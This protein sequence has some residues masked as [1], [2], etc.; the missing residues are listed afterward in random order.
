[1]HAPFFLRSRSGKPPLRIGVLL[2]TAFLPACF[3]EVLDHIAQSNF[4]RLEIAVFNGEAGLRSAPENGGRRRMLFDLYEQWD[5]KRTGGE[6]DPLQPVDCSPRLKGLESITVTPITRGAADEF[7]EESIR[8]IREKDLDVIIRFGFGRPAGRILNAARYGVWSYCRDGKDPY[9]DYFWEVYDKDFLSRTRLHIL[10]QEPEADQVLYE[11]VFAAWIGGSWARNRTQPLWG[12]T[13]FVIQKLL[14]LHEQG[15]ERVTSEA[16]ATSPHD[17]K[18]RAAPANWQMVR[19]FVPLTLEKGW[20]RL[21]TAIRGRELPHWMLA[22]SPA[23]GVSIG[24]NGA[25][26]LKRFHWIDSPPDH[27]YA[28]PFLVKHLDKPWVF[29]EDLDYRTQKG[30]IACAE[31]IEDGRLS[32]MIPALERPYHLSYPCVFRD[33]GQLYMIPESVANQSVELYRCL[34]FPDVWEPVKALL[35]APAVD[36][37]IWIEDG[38][39]WFFVTLLEPRGAGVQLWLFHSRSLTGELTSHVRNPISTD[40]RY[41]RGAGAIYRE[42]GKLIRPSQ[43]CSGTYGRRLIWNEILALNEREYMERP[44]STVEPEGVRNMI[45]THTYSRVDDVEV[46]DGCALIPARRLLGAG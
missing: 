17:G 42:N 39:Y 12:A 24:R 6:P 30:V 1:M 8:R 31:V 34:R 40:I 13:T 10:A 43:D 37:T 44:C 3:A 26:D 29:F 7:P 25:A 36:T 28:D 41:S 27:F 2:D 38:M 22:V 33:G 5:G 15:W 18:K 45:G 20:V 14:Q 35:E 11:G 4:A 19:W 32:K 23:E 16:T 21:R 46:I 9:L